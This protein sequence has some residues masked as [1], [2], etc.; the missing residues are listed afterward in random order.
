[1]RRIISAILLLLVFL[2]L[3]FGKIATYL[4]CKWQVEIVLNQT[5][6]GCDDHLVTMFSHDET[7]T[8]S[9]LSK[10][11]LNDK[12]NEFNP[13][14]F[15]GLLPTPFS[16]HNSFTNYHAAISETFIAPPFHPPIA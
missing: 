14:P 16:F 15:I 13:K 6:C 7:G 2:S 10:I 5:D 1:M 3:Q 12:I 4:Y 11:A 9:S 8:D